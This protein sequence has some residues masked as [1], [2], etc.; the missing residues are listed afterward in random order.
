MSPF[1][2]SVSP[3]NTAPR[4]T[5]VWAAAFASM[6]CASAAQA[7]FTSASDQASIQTSNHGDL[8]TAR[9][10][11][12][13]DDSTA[14][15]SGLDQSLRGAGFWSRWEGRVGAVIERPIS[16]LQSTGAS[17]LSSQTTAQLRS[18]HFLSDYYFKGG[19]RATAGLVHGDVD[20]AWWSST[21]DGGG[22]NLSV[23]TIDTLSPLSAAS[24][25]PATDT[26]P[27]TLPYLGAGYTS[28]LKLKGQPSPWRFNADLGVIKINSNNINRLTQ[29]VQG[30][31][32]MLELLRDVRLKPVFKVSVGYSF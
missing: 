24:S 23:Q 6:L 18:L 7:Q 22:L 27:Q 26:A 28:R 8:V 5:G 19:I 15:N 9:I 29:I 17:G 25:R 14:S 21:Q 2:Q 12:R 20:Q 4:C 10:N 1:A 13:T 30:D 31:K 3:A 11:W 16:P 32:S